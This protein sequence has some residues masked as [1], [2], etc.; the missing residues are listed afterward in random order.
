VSF[1]TTDKTNIDDIQVIR[2]CKLPLQYLILC[3]AF[4][5][6]YALRLLKIQECK[7]AA[8]Q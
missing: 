7:G 4:P 6:A 5:V 2:S 3:C 1:V 8:A